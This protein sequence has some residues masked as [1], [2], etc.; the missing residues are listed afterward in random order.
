MLKLFRRQVRYTNG[1]LLK[2]RPPDTDSD[3]DH[4]LYPESLNSAYGGE[5]QPPIYLATKLPGKRLL[6]QQLHP[7]P[8]LFKRYPPLS[9][10]S[11]QLTSI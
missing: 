9:F 6:P 1:Q 8:Q 4:D 7:P 2:L 10:N 11:F 5:L 3:S